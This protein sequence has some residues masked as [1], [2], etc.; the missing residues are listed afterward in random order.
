MLSDNGKH[1]SSLFELARVSGGEWN[2]KAYRI[3]TFAPHKVLDLCEGNTTNGTQVI[4]YG[5]HI[6]NNQVWLVVPA[7]QAV[8]KYESAG[9]ANPFGFNLPNLNQP[10]FGSFPKWG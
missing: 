9:N 3:R 10:N 4:Q 6:N 1:P 5:E 2:N 7:D 8:P